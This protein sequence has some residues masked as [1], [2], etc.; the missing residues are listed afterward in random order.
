MLSSSF[1]IA[2]DGTLPACLTIRSRVHLRVAR[3]YTL[4]TQD[5]PNL[6]WLCAPKYAPA[7][8]IQRLAE[9]QKPG[10]WRREGCGVRCVADGKQ[11]M[12]AEIMTFI[13]IMVWTFSLAGPAWQDLTMP[14][15]HCVDNCS[16]RFCR[17]G[18]Q[19]ELG[20]SRSP[21]PI[22]QR[23]LLLA[24]HQLWVYVC[25]FGLG[26]MEM[27]AMVMAMA[28]AMAMAMVLVIVITVPEVLRQVGWLHQCQH[29]SFHRLRAFYKPKLPQT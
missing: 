14:D 23:N 7:C 27:M 25:A 4:N 15:G 26:L 10:T 17:K 18:R 6:T 11:R 29:Q 24:S 2:L 8:S 22:F 5:T 21:T 3:K 20:E 28:I 9:L 12:A 19:F 1:P 16:V 13:D